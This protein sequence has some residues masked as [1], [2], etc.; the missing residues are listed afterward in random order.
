MYG[1]MR[2]RNQT[3]IGKETGMDI[4][5][6]LIKQPLQTVIGWDKL[7]SITILDRET[8]RVV[9]ETSRV[10][11][12]KNNEVAGWSGGTTFVYNN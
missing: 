10:E 5:R 11:D 1:I 12:Y 6:A 3:G 9:F 7:E 8:E 4:T 2:S